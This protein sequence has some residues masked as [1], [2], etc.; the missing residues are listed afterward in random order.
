LIA[1]KDDFAI[2]AEEAVFPLQLEKLLPP[3]ML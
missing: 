2:N 3:V 1:E